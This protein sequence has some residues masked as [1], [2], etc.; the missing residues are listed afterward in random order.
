MAA[1]RHPV[2]ARLSRS[3]AARWMANPRS[4]VDP[5]ALRAAVSGRVVLVTGAS[6][7]L[8]E[9]TARRLAH[10]GATVLLVARTADALDALAA[11]LCRAGG[12]AH[13]YPTDL[14]DP[15][16]V[17]ALTERVLREHG[18]V[19]VLVNNAGKS[20]RRSIAKSTGRFHDFER[21]IGVNYLGP[22]KLFLG[23]LP[24]MRARGRGHLV[25]IS[26]IGVQVPPAPRWVAYQASKTAFD[27][28]FRGVATEIARDGITA[29]SVYMPLIRTR[30]S[31][32]TRAFDD[33]PGMTADEAAGV[34]C[35][36]ITRRPAQISPWWA[37]LAE[38]GAAATRRPWQALAGRLSGASKHGASEH[39]GGGRGSVR[40]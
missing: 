37:D 22:V 19:D 3:G 14:T 6:Y 23:L 15:A 2:L 34:V 29:T 11:D 30:M 27:V 12:T 10:A 18:H 33:L 35:R 13:P 39:G 1:R 20:I 9:A 36:A 4:H 21:T 28:F 7:G 25:N 8:G 24:A 17:E 26:T 31:A 5:A 38:L 16:Q 32:P 40:A